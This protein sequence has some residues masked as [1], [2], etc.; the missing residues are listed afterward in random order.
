MEDIIMKKRLMICLVL[1]V[2]FSAL[3]LVV[4]AATI[5]VTD[6]YGIVHITPSSNAYIVQNDVWNDVAG[7]QTL[8]VDDQT[9]I[10][11]VTKATH[12]KATNS[13]PA[14]YPS[15]FKGWHYGTN[16][17]NSGMPKQVSAINTCSTTWSFVNP[18]ST[19][20]DVAN[21]VWINKTNNTA[22]A[23]PDG[24]EVMVWFGYAGSIQPIGSKVAT[25][26]INSAT[27]DLWYG[28]A[29]SWNVVTY[30]KTATTTSGSQNLKSF[31][32]DAKNRGY[33]QAT[34]YLMGV[35]A[36]TEL[37]QGGV[38]YKSNAF[39]CTVN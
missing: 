30:K 19:A 24:L 22:A 23:N 39:T 13:S 18:T 9:G 15:I 20:Y 31:I 11:S 12:N 6:N 7:S 37:W 10:F 25:V 5:L 17:T 34:W 36:G 33:C 2:A 4:Y 1:I 28:S 8:S 32:T 21:D 14:S 27:W 3:S 35:E 16:T 38:N 29:G 26:T